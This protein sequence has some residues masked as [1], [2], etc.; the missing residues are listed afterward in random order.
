MVYSDAF[1]RF[2]F[3]SKIAWLPRVGLFCVWWN[4][5]WCSWFI[6]SRYLQL[7]SLIC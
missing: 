4:D 1:V 6:I 3:I 7:F 5:I 2:Y